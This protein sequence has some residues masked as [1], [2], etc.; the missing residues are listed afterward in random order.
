MCNGFLQSFCFDLSGM[1]PFFFL[2]TFIVVYVLALDTVEVIVI[3]GWLLVV[4]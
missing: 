1:W 3:S 2:S 4:M